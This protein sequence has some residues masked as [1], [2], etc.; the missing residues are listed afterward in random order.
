M[1][2]L[3]IRQATLEDFDFVVSLIGSDPIADARQPARPDDQIHQ[4]DAFDAIARDP[5]HLLLVAEFEH[6]RVGSF[7]LSFIPGVSRQGAWRGQIESVRIH[8]DY[9]NRGLGSAMMTWAVE[10][11]RQRGCGLVQLTSDRQRSSAHRFYERLGFSPTHTGFR[12]SLSV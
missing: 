11:C 12:L 10:R 9:R 2:A 6:Q 8:P 1:T 7:Q 4:R 5:N 3:S